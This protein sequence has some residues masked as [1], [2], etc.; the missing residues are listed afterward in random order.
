MELNNT[1]EQKSIYL[2]GEQVADYNPNVINSVDSNPNKEKNNAYYAANLIGDSG[3][4]EKDETQ[5]LYDQIKSEYEIQGFSNLV[6]KAQEQLKLEDDVQQKETI[7]TIIQDP[8]VSK[9]DKEIV[10]EKY[11]YGYNT[12]PTLETKYIEKLSQEE[13]VTT[14]ED[15]IVSYEMNL[16]RTFLGNKSMEIGQNVQQQILKI[17]ENN[18]I[19]EVNKSEATKLLKSLSQLNPG[20]TQFF[21]MSDVELERNNGFFMSTAVNVLQLVDALVIELLP[22]ITEL[23]STIAISGEKSA[24]KDNIEADILGELL[25]T[26]DEK[27]RA[28]K[29]WTELRDYIRKLYHADPEKIFGWDGKYIPALWYKDV[30]PVGNA[31]LNARDL[32]QWIF[33]IGGLASTP[34]EYEAFMAQESAV[35]KG[36]TKLDQWFQFAAEKITPEDPGKS[37]V[38]IEIGAFFS[39]WGA[40]KGI[41]LGVKTKKRSDFKDLGYDKTVADLFMEIDK[42]Q[43][44]PV[45]QAEVLAN[46]RSPNVKTIERSAD[47]YFDIQRSKV[48]NNPIEPNSA[49]AITYSTNPKKG[50]IALKKAIEDPSGKVAE[51]MNTTRTQLIDLAFLANVGLLTKPRHMD[52]MEWMRNRK[53]YETLGPEYFSNAGFLF[54]K[55]R[56]SWIKDTDNVLDLSTAGIELYQRNSDSLFRDTE[57]GLLAS[58]RFSESPNSNFTTVNS[59]IT[60]A[61]VISNQ[62]KKSGLKDFEIIIHQ[63]GKRDQIVQNFTTKSVKEFVGWKD[64]KTL[65]QLTKE[66]EVLLIEQNKNRKSKNTKEIKIVNKQLNDLWKQMEVLKQNPDAMTPNLQITV[67]R[68][69]DWFDV[70]KALTDGFNAP[71]K[72]STWFTKALFNTRGAWNWL[73]QFG[74][75]NKRFQEQMHS[76]GLMSQAWL[77]NHLLLIQKQIADL[78]QSQRADMQVLYGK[79]MGVAEVFS[80]EQIR[81]TL[82]PDLPAELAGKYQNLLYDTRALDKFRFQAEN[83]FELGRLSRE[84]Y[85][86]SYRAEI[87]NVDGKKVVKDLPVKT[88]FMWAKEKD[89]PPVIWDFENGR[90]VKNLWREV[91][92]KP[93]SRRFFE[94]DAANKIVDTGLPIYRLAYN[95]VTPDGRIYEYGIFRNQKPAELP[96][97]ILDFEVGHMPA[98]MTGTKFVR[99]YPKTL[100]VNGMLIDYS[101]KFSDGTIKEITKTGKLTKKEKEQ[102][103]EWEK[104]QSQMGPYK[105]AVMM[106]NTELAAK[107][108]LSSP[109]NR[110]DHG[111]VHYRIEDANELSSLDRIEAQVIRNQAMQASK[112]RSRDPIANAEYM[113]VFSAFVLTTESNGSRSFMAPALA[114]YKLRWMKEYVDNGRIKLEGQ[115]EPVFPGEIVPEKQFPIQESQILPLKHKGAETVHKQAL[116]EWDQIM[117]LDQG[118]ENNS[119]GKAISQLSGKIAK[120]SDKKLTNPIT[121]K[122]L[123]SLV[124]KFIQNQIVARG[125]RW[126]KKPTVLQNVPAR[127][128]AQLKIQ[129]QFPMWHWM[130]QTANSFGHLAVA[131]YA[132]LN[133]KTLDNYFY[134]AHQSASIVTQMLLNTKSNKKNLQGIIDGLDWMQKN[135][136]KYKD[137][138]GIETLTAK[139]RALII[140][141][142]FK[143]NL[144]HIS[145]HTFAKNFWKQGPRELNSAQFTRAVDKT[146]DFVGRIGFEQGEL[147]GR[148][149]TWMA[150]RVDWIQKNP[151]LNW[152]ST[153]AL[154]EITAGARKLAGSMD[155]FGEMRIQRVPILATFAQFSSFIFKSSEGLWNID[156]TPFNGKQMAALSAWNMG[157]YGIQAGMW[158]GSWVMVREILSLV[159]DEHELD[160]AVDKIDELS[161]L[162]LMMNGF[163]DIL[164]PTYDENGVLLKSDLEFNYRM[165]PMGADMPFG[166]YGQIISFLMQDG[167]GNKEFGPSGKLLKDIWGEHGF[168]DMLQAIWAPLHADRSNAIKIEAT[169]E[170]LFRLSGL[171]KGYFRFMLAQSIDDKISREGQRTGE[172]MT[173]LEKLFS[174]SSTGT[175]AERLSF[176][177]FKLDKTLKEQAK[178]HAKGITMSIYALDKNPTPAQI[179]KTLRAVK[180]AFTGSDYMDESMYA[181]VM[182]QVELTISRNAQGRMGSMYDKMVTT[183]KAE[184]HPSDAVIAIMK[185][186]LKAFESAWGPTNHKVQDLTQ[187]IMAMENAKAHYPQDE[188]LKFRKDLFDSNQEEY[189]K[190]QGK[191]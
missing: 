2:P 163:G 154:E 63:V 97:R 129:W 82:R 1:E 164:L 66:Y 33:R 91:N 106:A 10:L 184:P 182:K 107:T 150:A 173:R 45:T 152:R 171:G 31:A 135:A 28:T 156:A 113:D 15:E 60:A 6:L 188:S 166:G 99:A 95:H 191:D 179:A 26:D 162:N 88:D 34:E 149:N 8:N 13:L 158:Y 56:K 168:F 21:D 151:G 111:N 3:H 61:N 187:L 92:K 80:L 62:I 16:D 186:K 94:E 29:N 23:G 24:G 143:S 43:L 40:K 109:K 125:Y 25:L 155:S 167:M 120:Y 65:Q 115:K 183:Y 49:F 30:G 96:Q 112:M 189:K 20:Y 76:T 68:N 22:Y 58:I 165:S 153:L 50:E 110:R 157:V 123:P 27:F 116:K 86:Q 55:E 108:W 140:E 139:D 48:L 42:T 127:V 90:P 103:A 98:I 147:M 124:E 180:W 119:I 4:Y 39:I 174:W 51:S 35:V 59:A 131:G 93:Q 185:K 146:N 142:G 73:A 70:G 38:F 74:N 100:E 89:S 101:N 36:F 138:S 79:Q 133:R 128:T 144:F 72:R 145:D 130:I 11:L 175:R 169:A 5:T 114:E 122:P 7:T 83:L 14:P 81:M 75:M 67:K 19:T 181:E 69:T 137:N 102:L 170:E 84:G 77:K 121:G 117:I 132:G 141:N 53:M 161:L 177:A 159:F 105:K 136:D 172:D 12:K 32:L 148:V 78:N 176:E 9:Q 17:H 87:V 57:G 46:V 44:P 37:K 18:E 190:L 41:E 160:D 178:S 134:T 47:S 85:N 104:F 71:T 54:A 126:Q 52:A 64:G 118:F